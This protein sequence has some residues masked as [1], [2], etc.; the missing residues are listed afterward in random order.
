M[1]LGILVAML[2]CHLLR[3]SEGARVAGYICGLIV[4]DQSLEPWRY[5][6][7]RFVETGLGVSVAWL[8]SLVPKL[9]HIEEARDKE[10]S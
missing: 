8:V 7:F 9:V 4:L 5:A 2:I 1:G 3:A 6:F 10:A